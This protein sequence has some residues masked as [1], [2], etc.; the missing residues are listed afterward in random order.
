ME[1]PNTP[2]ERLVLFIAKV[3]KVVACHPL[4]RCLWYRGLTRYVSPTE[5][6]LSDSGARI[7]NRLL[8][9]G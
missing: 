1:K 7:A 5:M 9:G 6:A 3:G 8:Y 2:E 4:Y